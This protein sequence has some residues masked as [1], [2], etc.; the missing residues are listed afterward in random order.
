MQCAQTH[1]PRAITFYYPRYLQ[2]NCPI[3]GNASTTS[4]CGKQTLKHQNTE[5]KYKT[6]I[7]RY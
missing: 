5:F 4:K 7:Y 3:D 1:A 2:E 6:Y